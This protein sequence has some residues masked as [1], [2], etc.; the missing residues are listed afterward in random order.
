MIGLLRAKNRQNHSSSDGEAV[1]LD[2][3]GAT[4]TPLLTCT[5]G[6]LQP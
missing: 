5:I 3:D 1:I 4:G 2:V 6:Q